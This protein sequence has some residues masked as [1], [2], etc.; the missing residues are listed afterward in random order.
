MPITVALAKQHL[1]YEADDRYELIQQF[2]NAAAA[3]IENYTGKKL[4]VGTVVQTETSFDSYVHLSRGPFV[5]LTSIEYIDTAFAPQ[6]VTDALVQ[7]GRIYAPIS[8]WPTAAKHTPITIT[9]QAGFETTPADLI[10]AQ[11]LLVGHL[12]ANREAVSD[13]TISG[14][15]FGVEALCHPYREVLV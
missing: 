13:R 9:Y 15:P 8:G 2:I 14:V 4:E 6:T 11:L 1:E 3:W 5:S 10:S 12:F 7:S